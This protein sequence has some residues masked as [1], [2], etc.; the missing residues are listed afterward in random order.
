[1]QVEYKDELLYT[2][3][4]YASPDQAQPQKRKY[5]NRTNVSK[6][7]SSHHLPNHGRWLIGH[8]TDIKC[9]DWSQ[10]RFKAILVLAIRLKRMRIT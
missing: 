4:T 7:D 6:L 10:M 2:V 8:L 1:M 9:N 5:R 3:F